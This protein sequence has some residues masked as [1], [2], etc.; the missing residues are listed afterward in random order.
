MCLKEPC[1][2]THIATF[3]RPQQRFL[4]GFCLSHGLLAERIRDLRKFGGRSPGQAGVRQTA[5]PG[6]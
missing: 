6:N 1:G 5:H 2:K 4:G 3:E